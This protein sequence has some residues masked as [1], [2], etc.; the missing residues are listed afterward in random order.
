ML[1]RVAYSIYWT[2]RYLE[3]AENVARF[4][5]VN[6]D[7]TLSTHVSSEE[8]WLPL[9]QT[10]GDYDFFCQCHQSFD[11]DSVVSFLGYDKKSPNSIVNCLKMARGNARSVREAISHDMWQAINE[12]YLEINQK[13]VKFLTAK[14]SPS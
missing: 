10:S 11:Q 14:M 13:R 2:A 6:Q 1:S 5:A 9:V 4:L 12:L 3:R 8:L 7:L